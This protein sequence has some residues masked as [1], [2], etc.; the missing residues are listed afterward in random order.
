MAKSFA[1]RIKE[2]Q[3][4]VAKEEAALK[5]MGNGDAASKKA[6]TFASNGKKLSGE[7][8]DEED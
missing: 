5:K 8:S 6:K 2:L 7:L 1:D 4:Q 3:D